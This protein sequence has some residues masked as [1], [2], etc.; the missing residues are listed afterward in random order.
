M[1]SDDV[2]DDGI[3]KGILSPQQALDLRALAREAVASPL[4]EPEDD[5]K[6]RFITGF[7]DI[8]VTLGIGLFTGGIGYLVPKTAG[9]HGA[10]WIVL[11]FVSWGLAEFFTRRRR[12]AL[13][14][15]VLLCLFAVS[16]FLSA[17][18][19]IVLV[20]YD[21]TAFKFLVTVP[22][23]YTWE[24]PFVTVAA[25]TTLGM[26]ALHY[27]RFRVPITVAAGAAAL[28]V[29]FM[30]VINS[31]IPDL[32]IN[33]VRL[34]VT[35]A[36]LAVFAMAMRFDLSDPARVTRR[37]DIAF[38]LHLLAAPLIVHPFVSRLVADDAA[39]Q[40]GLAVA[41]L[42]I[43]VFL[44]VV[45]VVIDRRAILISGLGYAGYAFAQLIQRVGVT[46]QAVPATV[47]A[48]GAFVLLL[49]AGWRPTRKIVLGLLPESLAQKL[50]HPLTSS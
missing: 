36:G 5:E 27:W 9:G 26:V 39:P 44:G 15:I 47:L 24:A 13:P 6:L 37:T 41:V 25:L 31:V 35:I 30:A 21:I 11:T 32:S 12:M 34:A 19:L 33:L 14:S 23:L 2:L 29:A 3:S 17:M 40:M 7:N 48:L 46:D 50:P 22:L 20:A 10:L 4:A 45:A 28:T 42:G 16:A 1:I 43:F 49:S 38:W 8:F 18:A